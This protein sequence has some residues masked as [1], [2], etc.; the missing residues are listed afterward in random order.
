MRFIGSF[1]V[2]L[3]CALVVVLCEIGIWL[4][5]VAA[6]ASS[7]LLAMT[8]GDNA[9]LVAIAIFL[10]WGIFIAIKTLLVAIQERFRNP[11]PPPPRPAPT[12]PVYTMALKATLP[13]PKK[14]KR[15]EQV[16]YR[17]GRYKPIGVYVDECCSP[18]IAVML[19]GMGYTAQHAHELGHRSWKDPRHLDYAACARLLI[20]T[21]DEDFIALDEAGEPHAGI[22]RGAPLPGINQ[23]LVRRAVEALR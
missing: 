23:R 4:F 12:K 16:A 11:G 19:R 14:A 10:P 2:A 7:M 15:S 20:I 9:P 22:I 6:M 1:C 13:R 5:A 3:V 8:I 21:N 18:E 17:R